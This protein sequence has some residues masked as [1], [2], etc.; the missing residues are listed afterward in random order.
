MIFSDA[1]S[2]AGQ[3]CH[4]QPA[5]IGLTSGLLRVVAEAIER[6]AIGN[7]QIAARAESLYIKA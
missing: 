2:I 6:K 1:N 3:R 4:L 7:W 5:E